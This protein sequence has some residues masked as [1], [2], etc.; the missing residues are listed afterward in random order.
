MATLLSIIQDV[1]DEIG[2]TR[3]TSVY[4][5][6]DAQIR[7]LLQMSNREGRDIARMH[8]W[9]VLERLATI[10][11]VS[12]QAEYSLPTDFSRLLNL[13]AWDS[14]NKRPMFGAVGA[15]EWRAIKS[16]ALG[17]G[18]IDRRFRVIKSASAL[19]RVVEID[20]TPATSSESLTY[21]YIS[22]Y[23]CKDTGGTTG[24]SA[25]AADTDIPII[26]S[27]LLTLG[28]IIRFRRAKGFGFASEADE[29]Q[30]LFATLSGQ[31]RPAPV[32][33][34]SDQRRLVLLSSDNVPDT[35]YGA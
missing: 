9:T 11:T 6:T 27:D 15:M 22:T 4:A 19:T 33:N 31:D 13:T 26:D 2:I 23:W 20:P 34:W 21:E 29:Y 24:R 16:S 25:W 5:S 32:L 14:T 12:S 10:T 28:T 35:G 1:C 7:T 17:S 3:P 8:D 18:L 30:Q